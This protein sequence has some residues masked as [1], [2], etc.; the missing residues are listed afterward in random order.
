MECLINLISVN[1]WFFCEYVHLKLK[2]IELI[3]QGRFTFDTFVSLLPY[4]YEE[5]HLLVDKFSQIS[6]S[7]MLEENYF[8][9]YHL[10][11]K[12]HTEIRV[13]CLTSRLW[14][15]LFPRVNHFFVLIYYFL[16]V[17]TQQLAIVWVA[18]E[19]KP[20]SGVALCLGYFSLSEKIFLLLR[21]RKLA[22]FES[23]PTKL[24]GIGDRI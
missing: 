3:R 12:A 16:S 14:S 19:V 7:K 18:S 10:K 17:V 15:V 20:P 6:L 11:N 4:S 23:L 22:D 9:T 2:T 8:F 5:T 1:G 24:V 13:F 21:R